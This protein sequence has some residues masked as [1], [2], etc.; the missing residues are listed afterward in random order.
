VGWLSREDLLTRKG[1]AGPGIP[2]PEAQCIGRYNYRYSLRFL[3]DGSSEEMFD[4]SR[5]FLLDPVLMET[6]EDAKTPTISFFELEDGIHL[7]ALKISQNKDAVIAR[8]LNISNVPRKISF[9]KNVEIV[10][11][12]EEPTGKIISEFVLEPGKVLTVK[13]SK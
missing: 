13:S 9:R 6:S 10:N 11:L 1:H 3:S 7:S 2:T 4:A 8:F 5:R 12:A